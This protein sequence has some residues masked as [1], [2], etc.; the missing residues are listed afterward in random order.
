MAI[1]ARGAQAGIAGLCVLAAFAAGAMLA[2]RARAANRIYWANYDG[3][4][5]AYWNLDGTGGGGLDTGGAIDG[6]MGMALD[7]AHGQIYWANWD[8]N[9]VENAGHTI[10]VAN[11]D[12]SGEVSIVPINPSYVNGPHGLAID[13]GAGKLYWPNFADNTIGFANL[14]GSGAGHLQ[15][16]TATVSG[17][18][19]VAIDP[20]TQRIYWANYGPGGMGTTIS[21]ASLN[22]NTGANLMTIPATVDGPEGVAL[23]PPNN[24]MYWGNYGPTQ[25]G[26]T[27]AYANL[28]GT[29]NAHD[30]PTPG[31]TPH[32]V[33]GVALDPIAGRVYWA[34]YAPGFGTGSSAR[35]RS[36]E[37]APRSFPSTS[38][39]QRST[40]RC[41]RTCSTSRKGRALRRSLA[42]LLWVR[43]SAAVRGP[44]PATSLPHSST[45]PR[46]GL[47]TSGPANHSRS[48]GR[49]RRRSR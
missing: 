39:R 33:H 48:R 21:W 16:G 15:T 28:D 23:D 17:P 29:G 49:M 11:L 32:G 2:P 1:G 42:R 12:G 5:L 8:Q 20:T 9:G 26:D 4:S 3:E 34:N 44:G 13:P 27:I 41:F 35:P 40:V 31:V 18:R 22:N 6:P 25:T 37:A 46:S 7:P 10:G 19:G 43:P 24:R 45:G 14:D 47:P 38:P 30:L 36:T